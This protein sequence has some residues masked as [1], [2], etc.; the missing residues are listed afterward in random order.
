MMAEVPGYGRFIAG[1]W[2]PG[3]SGAAF[4]TYNPA[5]G[6]VI[7][8]VASAG[9]EDVERV[10]G[11]ARRAFDEGPWPKASGA[12]RARVLYRI[13]E[14]IEARADDLARLETTSSGKLIKDAR[15]QVT[16]AAACFRYYAGLAEKIWGQTVP[17]DDTLFAYTLREPIGVSLGITP[18]NSPL[19]MAAYMAAPALA[20]GNTVILKP[21]SAT[22]ITALLLG[23]I[24]AEAGLSEGALNAVAGPGSEEFVARFVAGAKAICLGDPLDPA[25]QMGPVISRGQKEFILGCVRPGLEEGARLA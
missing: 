2:S 6:E 3:Q 20:A 16:K 14:A 23:S 4:E 24:C 19:I 11:V 7:A 17:M 18:W 25:T 13:A 1:A 22:P 12:V 10:V 5:T 9:P 8:R 15:G 21:A